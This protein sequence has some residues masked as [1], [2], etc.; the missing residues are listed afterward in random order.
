MHLP[1]TARKI[2][3]T[4][5]SIS[6]ID[7]RCFRYGGCHDANSH[8]YSEK[9]KKIKHDNTVYYP[10]IALCNPNARLHFNSQFYHHSIATGRF[11]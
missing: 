1:T 10:K 11:C 2:L 5:P 4:K 8:K 7:P 9:P 3:R 6:K